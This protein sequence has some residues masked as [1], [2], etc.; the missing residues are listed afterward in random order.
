VG[1]SGK[2]RGNGALPVGSPRLRVDTY[3][4][5]AV[6]RMNNGELRNPQSRLLDS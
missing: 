3:L 2:P 5:A 1:F 4:I 6:G